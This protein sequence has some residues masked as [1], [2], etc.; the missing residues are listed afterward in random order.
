MAIETTLQPKYTIRSFAIVVISVVFGLWGLYDYYVKIPG[1]QRLYERG[2]VYQAVNDA[3]TDTDFGSPEARAK[4]KTAA[5]VVRVELE[6]LKAMGLSDEGLASPETL[7]EELADEDLQ[8]WFGELLMFVIGLNETARRSAEIP[9]SE[10]L[11]KIVDHVRR[12]VTQTADI[13]PPSKFD[14]AIQW[15]FILCLPCAPY[16]LWVWWKARAQRYR[17]DDD[18]TLTTP[19][20]T[21]PRAEIADIDMSRWMA[22]SVAE[23]VHTDGARVKLDDYIYR[24]MHEIVGAIA[25]ERHPEEW[26]AEAKP[27]RGPEEVDEEPLDEDEVDESEERVAEVES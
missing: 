4:I 25:S 20:G 27:Q 1:Q 6:E 7:R 8:Q 23:V 5:D 26:D 13:S 24:H 19:A 2:R 15:A 12:R 14:R 3:L 22:K 18:G 17:L 16:F 10:E 21:W 11:T 9:A